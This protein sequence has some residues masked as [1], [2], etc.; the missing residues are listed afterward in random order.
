M[1]FHEDNLKPLEDISSAVFQFHLKERGGWWMLI[2]PEHSIPP[3]YAKIAID[4]DGQVECKQFIGS[5]LLHPCYPPPYC[6]PASWPMTEE[7]EAA[8]CAS[9]WNGEA[10]REL[11]ARW[12]MEIEVLLAF[13]AI[14]H[15]NNRPID[16]LWGA[17][18]EWDLLYFTGTGLK[19]P[20]T[21][22][23]AKK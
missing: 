7:E 23:E 2:N 9:W 19:I 18:M 20:T 5:R 13:Q 3:S 17:L 6:K 8:W 15:N 4:H 12:P 10:A 1:I 14:K 21:I 16:S 11:F 22:E